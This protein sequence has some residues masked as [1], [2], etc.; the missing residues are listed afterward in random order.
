MGVGC[1]VG[2]LLVE[3]VVGS[4]VLVWVLVLVWGAV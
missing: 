1:M 4:L 3:G 2:V